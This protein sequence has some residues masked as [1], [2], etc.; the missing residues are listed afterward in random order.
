MRVTQQLFQ[1]QPTAKTIDRPS[2]KIIHLAEISSKGSS[3][4]LLLVFCSSTQFEINFR[5]GGEC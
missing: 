5:T 4:L 2:L 3:R 1:G